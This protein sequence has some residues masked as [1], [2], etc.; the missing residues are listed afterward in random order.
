MVGSNDPRVLWASDG[1]G[2][3]EDFVPPVPRLAPYQQGV[4]E[5]LLDC[6]CDFLAVDW[7]ALPVRPRANHL[8]AGSTGTGKTFLVEELA[9]RLKLPYLRLSLVNWVLLGCTRRGA[10]ATLPLIYRFVIAHPRGVIHLDELDKVGGKSEWTQAVVLEMMSAL[11]REVKAGVLGADAPEPDGGEASPAAAAPDLEALET[12]RRRVQRRFASGH[13]TVA[14]GAFQ[15]RLWSGAAAR[16]GHPV[17]EHVIDDLGRGLPRQTMAPAGDPGRAYAALTAQLPK[18]L[19]NRFSQAILYLPPMDRADYEALLAEVLDH[20]P[21]HL[22]G[23]RAAVQAEGQS[24]LGN[25]LATAQGYRWAE[26]VM[27]RAVRACRRTGALATERP[28]RPPEPEAP[29]LAVGA[30]PPFNPFG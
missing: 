15:A 12:E 18:E 9:R 21:A 13:L 6:A 10:E 19:V 3:P 25:A 8:L 28:P 2:D 16:S 23:L 11:D 14:T 27:G 5:E 4:F 26:E 1:P 24:S 30:L 17:W 29:Q 7:T 22:P 20:L